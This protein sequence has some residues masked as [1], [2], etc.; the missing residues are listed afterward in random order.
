MKK[1]IR[2]TLFFLVPM[3]VFGIAMGY[4]RYQKLMKNVRKAV[5]KYEKRNAYFVGD[6][7]IEAID[8]YLYDTTYANLGQGGEDIS[9]SVAKI[10]IL[11]KN[12]TNK[13]VYLGFA[14]NN[15]VNNPSMKEETAR[16]KFKFDLYSAPNRSM[17]ILM[18]LKEFIHFVTFDNVLNSGYG[19]GRGTTVTKV[20]KPKDVKD[21]HFAVMHFH[22]LDTSI[23][24]SY[25]LNT[26]TDLDNY[27]KSRQSKLI[28]LNTPATVLYKQNIPKSVFD[29][30]NQLV[31]T[32][33]QQGIQVMNYEKLDLND[34]LF[35]DMNHLNVNGSKTILSIMFPPK[36]PTTGVAQ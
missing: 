29:T 36:T 21:P 28:L 12:T 13:T 30:Y 20:F 26:V 3:L 17:F 27:L 16:R 22:Y 24:R 15:I 10:K 35:H 4:M 34:S 1:F 6:S 2:Y 31:N 25:L 8:A 14:E 7:H 33:A 23:N 32:F 9:V 5:T 11:L 18:H 19:D